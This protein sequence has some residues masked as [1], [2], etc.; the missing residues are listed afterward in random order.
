MKLIDCV[1]DIA[2]LGGIPLVPHRSWVTCGSQ[3]SQAQSI[4]SHATRLLN[5][6]RKSATD[7]MILVQGGKAASQSHQ[8]VFGHCSSMWHGFRPSRSQLPP[9]GLS[10]LAPIPQRL[11]QCWP[12]ADEE[13]HDGQCSPAAQGEVQRLG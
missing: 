9:G 13:S 6:T 3:T 12:A 7:D 2:L 11:C 10:S 5:A 4:A 1:L 8:P